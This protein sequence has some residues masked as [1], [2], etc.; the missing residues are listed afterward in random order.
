[1]QHFDQALQ[2][3][4]KLG[5]RQG[6]LTFAQVNDYL[7][8]EDVNPDRLDDL[9]ESIE[10]SGLEI[11][12]E[13]KMPLPLTPKPSAQA[14]CNPKKDAGRGTSPKQSR[15]KKAKTEQVTAAAPRHER[16]AMRDEMGRF[17][18]PLRLYLT[19]MGEYRL[20]SKDEEISQAK[21]IEVTRK[22]FRRSLFECDF[23][24]KTAWE[25][26][27]K[28]REG[29]LPFDRTVKVSLTEGL[30]RDQILGRMPHNLQTLEL[31]LEK[32]GRDFAKAT[33][34]SRTQQE[35]DESQLVL[36]RRRRKAATLLE[37]MSL[38]T[39]RLL[40]LLRRLEQMSRRMTALDKR[41]S[42]R[43]SRSTKEELANYKAELLDLMQVTRE[44]PIESGGQGEP[45]Q[46]ASF[47][48]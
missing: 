37:E 42:Q 48:V 4:I 40:P 35:R 34:A 9:I 28:V 20:L 30:D 43:E 7:P 8:D 17:D 23:V 29:K 16:S 1:M 41:L 31:L 36:K 46:Q 47:R 15:P 45:A 5:K 21:M 11:R 10:E 27:E 12:D 25:V 22:Q 13:Q 6:Y 3:L 2:E 24:A 18:D 26:L 14:Q 32:N 33:D 39:Q 44:T 38:R 19:Q